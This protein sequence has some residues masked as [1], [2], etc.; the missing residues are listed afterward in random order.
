MYRHSW[1]LEKC[2]EF[3]AL[4]GRMVATCWES[5]DVIARVNS[6]PLFDVSSMSQFLLPV[7]QFC[8]ELGT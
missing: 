7:L 6:M 4:E 5:F 3:D 8:T 2:F 1:H